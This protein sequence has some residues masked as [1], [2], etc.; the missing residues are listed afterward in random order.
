MASKQKV[1]KPSSADV[2]TICWLAARKAITS[3]TP[4]GKT[5]MVYRLQYRGT[6]DIN[7]S[8][9]SATRKG[10]NPPPIYDIDLNISELKDKDLIMLSG[11][12]FPIIFANKGPAN[13]NPEGTIYRVKNTDTTVRELDDRYYCKLLVRIG[14]INA[15]AG[16]SAFIK[17]A[18]ADKM[19]DVYI[20][21][22]LK[23]KGN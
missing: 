23:T 3:I 20:R 18:I 9:I 17:Q 22:V 10:K 19:P 15:P 4:V 2:E 14:R 11:C 21:A 6:F 7:F 16:K 12:G 13:K 1:V 8:G 5:T